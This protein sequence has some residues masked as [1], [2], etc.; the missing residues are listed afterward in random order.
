MTDQ[1]EKRGLHNVK[2]LFKKPTLEQWTIFILLLL[3]IGM[4]LQFKVE[5][6]ECRDALVALPST[7][8]QICSIQ[9]NVTDRVSMDDD[10]RYRAINNSLAKLNDTDDDKS[11]KEE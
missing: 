9:I 11:F 2:N 10:S 5:T 4:A 1:I 3:S 8:C 7:A 6:Q